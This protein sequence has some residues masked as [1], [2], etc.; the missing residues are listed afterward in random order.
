[1]REG[2]DEQALQPPSRPAHTSRGAKPLP[3]RTLIALGA[4]AGCR[5]NLVF[6]EQV[7][8]ALPQR[9]FGGILRRAS[10]RFA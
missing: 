9:P 10:S 2:A 1:V 6:P 3:P 7:R 4:C 8:F 5:L